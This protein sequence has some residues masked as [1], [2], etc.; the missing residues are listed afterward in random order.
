MFDKLDM[1]HYVRI[2][3]LQTAKLLGTQQPAMTQE[4]FQFKDADIMEAYNSVDFGSM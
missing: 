4:Y 3:R 2:E 1:Q